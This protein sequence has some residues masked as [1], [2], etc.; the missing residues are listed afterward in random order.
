MICFYLNNNIFPPCFWVGIGCWMLVG[1]LSVCG[2][3]HYH[4]LVLFQCVNCINMMFR[5]IIDEMQALPYRWSDHGCRLFLFF[6]SKMIPYINM[7][8]KVQNLLR[9]LV[10]FFYF[11]FFLFYH[12]QVVVEFCC[13]VRF[14][15]LNPS[16]VICMI[17]LSC[18]IWFLASALPSA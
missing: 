12:Y 1:M 16:E 3:S 9:T 2:C 10:S 7:S 14:L 11:I 17:C 5:C 15:L 18:S 4:V 8:L 13:H 6:L